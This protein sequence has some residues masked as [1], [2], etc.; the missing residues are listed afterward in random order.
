MFLYVSLSSESSLDTMT[1]VLPEIKLDSSA[2]DWEE[3]MVSWARHKEKFNLTGP[4]LI[5]QL[6]ACLKF[7]D[8]LS[9]QQENIPEGKVK[10]A[11]E[12][13]DTKVPVLS[14]D[15]CRFGKKSRHKSRKKTLGIREQDDWLKTNKTFMAEDKSYQPEDFQFNSLSFGEVAAL[16]YSARKVTRE[17]QSIN[18]VKIPHMLQQ[19]MKWIVRSRVFEDYLECGV[20]GQKSRYSCVYMRYE[21][22]EQ[23]KVLIIN[24][25]TSRASFV[26]T[27]R[28]YR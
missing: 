3:L 22:F 2:E 26:F 5:R 23:L 24:I 4:G 15:K 1:P 25:P 7:I 10:V 28:R 27:K 18:K 21:I 11:S 19:D 20:E 6:I 9:D 8:S 13:V 12:I 16:M 17:M 14:Q